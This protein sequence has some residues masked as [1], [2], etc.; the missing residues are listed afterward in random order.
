M[1]PEFTGSE[2]GLLASLARLVSGLF[3]EPPPSDY[4][5]LRTALGRFQNQLTIKRLAQSYVIE[6]SYYSMSPEQSAAIANAVAEGYIVDS[7]ESKY[8]ASRRAAVGC[9]T[10]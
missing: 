8:Q 9:R 6:I 4:S 7:L 5:L 1:M 2:G 3:P 10:G